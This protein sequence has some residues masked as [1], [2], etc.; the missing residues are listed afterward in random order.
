[1]T[2]KMTLL[3]LQLAAILISA[4]LLGYL[5][6]RYLK[7]PRVLG[8]LAAGMIIGPYALGAIHLPGLEGSLFPL[9]EGT[10]PVGPE[11]YGFAVFA[12]IVLLFIAG[13]ET[14]LPTFLRFSGVG[15]AVGLG[16]VVV[17]FSL[18]T[19]AAYFFLP[20]VTSLMD[21]AALFL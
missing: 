21:P 9:V 17:S 14:D 2:H 13:L 10:L 18:G 7:Q 1:M 4:K 5:A 11:L 6:E 3:V 19:L 12:S 20:S 16:G 8:E 15:T